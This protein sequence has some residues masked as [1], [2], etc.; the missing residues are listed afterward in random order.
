MQKGQQRSKSL[1]LNRATRSRGIDHVQRT[2]STSQ[3]KIFC[4]DPYRIGR[5]KYPR[6][7]RAE[8]HRQG[9]LDGKALLTP[10][11]I[12]GEPSD[13]DSDLGAAI[14]S[15]VATHLTIQQSVDSTKAA[16][17]AAKEAEEL[18]AKAKAAAAKAKNKPGHI[19]STTA[20]APNL[21]DVATTPSE[22]VG[23]EAPIE[24]DES[25]EE[26]G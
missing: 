21:F 4:P 9:H 18:A 11:T 3:A 2:R 14:T 25:E 15:Y 8:G 10:L 13:L 5:R 23:A 24:T 12:T 1:L 6:Q 7:L 20:V 17:K 26:E 19:K 16:M 22:P